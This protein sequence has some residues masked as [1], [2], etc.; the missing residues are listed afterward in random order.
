MNFTTLTLPPFPLLLFE[1]TYR[2]IRKN[3]GKKRAKLFL[4]YLIYARIN[5]T[6]IQSSWRGELS[7]FEQFFSWESFIRC[8]LYWRGILHD[9]C[10]NL[11]ES[12]FYL[13]IIPRVDY[14]PLP[15]FAFL[16]VSAF[17]FS[18]RNYFLSIW[19]SLKIWY[20]HLPV[21]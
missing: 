3:P 21:K 20:C 14:I 2:E 13:K 1:F 7:K 18:L 5:L 9:Y 19:R 12:E 15:F 16:D 17:R 10:N 8:L 4:R 6:T 11:N